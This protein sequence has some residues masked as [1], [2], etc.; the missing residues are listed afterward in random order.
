MV[1]QAQTIHR[2][3][4]TNYFSVFDHFVRLALKVITGCYSTDSFY[5]KKYKI[6]LNIPESEQVTLCKK[7]L[8]NYGLRF[9]KKMRR[10]ARHDLYNLKNVKNSHG[11]VLL[12]VKLQ[13]KAYNFTK[14]NTLP[15]V[16]FKF[17][18]TYKWY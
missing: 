6:I 3:Q 10:F 4:P 16:F 5:C 8:E 17:F 12:L 9:W 13:A 14:S 2:E 11:E 7:I 1:K 18:K 15:W